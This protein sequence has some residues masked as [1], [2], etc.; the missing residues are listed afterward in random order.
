[1]LIFS[2]GAELLEQHISNATPLLFEYEAQAGRWR[3]SNIA[4]EHVTAGY[5][6]TAD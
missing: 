4:P 3:I 6:T 1:M 2:L 5:R